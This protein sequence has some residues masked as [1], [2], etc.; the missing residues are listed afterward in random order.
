MN[1]LF[2][3]EPAVLSIIQG[4]RFEVPITFNGGNIGLVGM[5]DGKSKSVTL[6]IELPS[7]LPVVAYTMKYGGN[8]ITGHLEGHSV[9]DTVYFERE[10]S[11]EWKEGPTPQPPTDGGQNLRILSVDERGYLHEAVVALA[12]QGDKLGLSFQETYCEQLF[13]AGDV[14]TCP[15]MSSTK[16]HT[17]ALVRDL[18]QGNE[19]FVQS[20]PAASTYQ[21]PDLKKL[22]LPL[23]SGEGLTLWYSKG[24]Q[25]GAVLTKNGVAKIHFSQIQ[26]DRFGF[27]YLERG[28]KVLF[29]GTE[30]IKGYS[31]F[32]CQLTDVVV[33]GVMPGLV[34]LKV[35]LDPERFQVS[36]A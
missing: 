6:K 14:I 1:I 15:Q 3:G 13:K 33:K 29:R 31:R 26:T 9:G 11:L 19:A 32:K 28:E 12:R 4:G 2:Y 24:G 5:I 7:S 25:N 8:E 22:A 21:R 35:D 17:L 20:L 10:V 27:R 18:L 34:D 16:Q 23:K 36:G 30:P